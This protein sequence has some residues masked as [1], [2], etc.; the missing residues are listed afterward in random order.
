MG[1]AGDEAAERRELFGLDQVLLRVSQLRQSLFG[2]FLGGPQ[3]GLGPILG[4]RVLA[5][6]LDGTRHVA[7]FVAGR[8]AV[9]RPVVAAERNRAHCSH[10]ALERLAD[11]LGHHHAADQHEGEE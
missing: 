6:H 8:G 1:D 10:Q 11:A 2:T 4:D 5:K 9:G 7:D 3:I